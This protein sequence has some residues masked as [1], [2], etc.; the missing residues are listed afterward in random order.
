MVVLDYAIEGATTGTVT[1]TGPYTLRN[2]AT[3]VLIPGPRVVGAVSALGTGAVS[4][5]ATDDPSI[6][7]S[8]WTYTVE[9]ATDVLVARFPITVPFATV[10]TLHLADLAPAVVPPAVV[11]YALASAVTASLALKAD[12]TA[13]TASLA[14]KADKELL[15]GPTTADQTVVSSAVL[16]DAAPSTGPALSV[17]VAALSSYVVDGLILIDTHFTP[18]VLLALVGPAGATMRWV[19]GGRETGA[20]NVENRTSELGSSRGSG[21]ISVGTEIGLRPSGLLVVG[22]TAG[23]FKVQFAQVVSDANP[24]VLKAGSYLTL[25]KVA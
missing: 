24:T 15:V 10:G 2:T 21:G 6:T 25:R 19:V 12:A 9:I 11:S 23:T 14:L 13:V 1:F 5:L 18:D 20:G 8:G 4:L 22:A 3:D 16:V 7:P 17:A